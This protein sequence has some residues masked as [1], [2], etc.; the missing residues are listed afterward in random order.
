MTFRLW[1]CLLYFLERSIFRCKSTSSTYP[2][3]SVAR[4]VGW[5]VA[6]TYRF[7]LCRCLWT[8]PL[9]SARGPQ[10]V[11]YFLKAMNDSYQ[12]ICQWGGVKNVT[13]NFQKKWSIHEAYSAKTFS[14]QAYLKLT[15]LPSFC[16]LVGF[17]VETS[18]PPP[19]R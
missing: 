1:R 7:P 13:N 15:H 5:S 2:R 11:I 9:Q 14:N 17:I 16:E 6:H 4:L 19:I 3:Q 18:Y 10:D 8:G 12:K